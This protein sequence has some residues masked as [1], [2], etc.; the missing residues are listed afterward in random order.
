MKRI[1]RTA[2]GLLP[3]CAQRCFRLIN[4]RLALASLLIFIPFTPAHSQGIDE[5]KLDSFFDRL[6]EKNEAMGSLVSVKDGRTLYSRSIGYS[7]ISETKKTPI[8]ANTRF[9]VGSVTKMF[10]AVMIL[11]LVEEGKLK[12]NDRLDKYL[13]QIPNAD[14]ITIAQILAHRSGIHD[15]MADPALRPRRR[16][17]QVTK[18]DML[19]MIAKTKSDFEPG[20][21]YAYS[22]SGYLILGYLVEILTAESYEKGVQE[23]ITSSIGLNDTYVAME[24]INVSKNESFSYTR[25]ANWRK[26]PETHWSML[27]GSG[28]LISTPDDLAIFIQ[29]LYGGKLV[30]QKSLTRMMVIEDGYGLGIDTFPLADRTFYG[31]TGGIDGFGSWLAYLPEEKLTIAYATNAKSYPVANIIGGVADVHFGR[32]FQIPAFESITVSTEIL[33]EYVGKYVRQGAPVSFAVSR[34]AA[35]LY[36]S[37]NGGPQFPLEATSEDTFKLENQGMVL[38]FDKDHKEMT[39]RRGNSLRVFKKEN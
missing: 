3:L 6:N 9:R 5:D 37:V 23:R 24:G 7:E 25:L 22:N 4:K 19:A 8:T 28:S 11:Q 17:T 39:L 38:E 36:I 13:P 34:K 20:T 29:A 32:P 18:E 15:I 1:L 16:T 10:T 26:Q 27:F 30:S 2:T 14:K 33:D 12:L 35:V 31:H 21:Q